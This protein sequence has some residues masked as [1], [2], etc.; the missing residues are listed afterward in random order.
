MKC[1]NCDL[2]EIKRKCCISVPVTDAERDRI[3]ALGYS[4]DYFVWTNKQWYTALQR[5]GEA[6]IN[7]EHMFISRCKFLNISNDDVAN[8]GKCIIYPNRP[9][10]CRDFPSDDKQRRYCDVDGNWEGTGY[11]THL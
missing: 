9:Q 11:D 4:R 5:A 8:N 10:I 3:M 6:D 2:Y 7:E 1:I